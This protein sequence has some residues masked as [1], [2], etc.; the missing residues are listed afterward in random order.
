MPPM[1]LE[2]DSIEEYLETPIVSTY[3]INQHGGGLS[4]WT[5]ELERR[6][7]VARMALD[8]LTVP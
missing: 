2:R 7:H 3:V 8:L 6:P 1:H 5:F 4:Y